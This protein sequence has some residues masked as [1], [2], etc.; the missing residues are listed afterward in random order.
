MED[1][2]D[3]LVKIAKQQRLTMS[4]IRTALSGVDGSGESSKSFLGVWE[5]VIAKKKEGGSA[6]TAENYGWALSSFR[7][8]I[9]EIEGFEI[10]KAVI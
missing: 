9:G 2:R 10:N 5:D 8:I 6:G 3:K 7:K 1:S 4:L